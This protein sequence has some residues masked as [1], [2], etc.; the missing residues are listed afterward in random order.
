MHKAAALQATNPLGH[1]GE[2][3]FADFSEQEF[4]VY[5]NLDMQKNKL[6]RAQQQSSASIKPRP[7]RVS[8]DAIPQ[9]LDWRTHGV[10]TPV[11]NQGQCGSCWAFSTTGNIEGQWAMAGN[12]LTS[13]SEQELVSCSF[14]SLGCD[15]GD[16]ILSYIW[17]L[18][19][20]GGSI[21]TERSDPYQ[22]INGSSPACTAKID[23][24]VTGAQITSYEGIAHDEGEM[25]KWMASYGPISICLD[26]TSFQTYTGGI[27]TDCISQ[28]VDHCV[29][30]VGYD[31]GA[32]VPYWLIKNSWSPQWGEQGYVRVAKGSNQCLITSEP[33]SSRV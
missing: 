20:H 3:L 11:K 13:V 33:S 31:L 32:S 23:T 10:V 7:R 5:H 4:K 19:I 30:L 24:G 2:N 26:A 16:T 1:F 14:L 27:I 9:T 8:N 15:G 21:A 6:L 28:S 18:L 22:S 25:A 29:L 17:L 12:N